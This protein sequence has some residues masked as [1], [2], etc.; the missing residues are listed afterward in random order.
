MSYLPVCIAQIEAGL[1]LQNVVIVLSSTAGIELVT[2]F[3]R[4]LQRWLDPTDEYA[5]SGTEVARMTRYLDRL[6]LQPRFPQMLTYLEGIANGTNQDPIAVNSEYLP[7][8]LD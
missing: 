1:F 8:P 6:D 3:T 7:T 2:G 5:L 4:D